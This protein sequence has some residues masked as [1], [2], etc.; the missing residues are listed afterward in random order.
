MNVVY[1]R[2][3][4]PTDV[5]SMIF[6]AGPTPRDKNVASWRGQAL[7][8]LARQGYTGTVFVPETRE[9]TFNDWGHDDVYRD[10]VEWEEAA[11]NRSDCILFWI[12]R[13]MAIMPGMTTNTEWGV[14]HDSGR[15]VL[16]TPRGAHAVKYQQYYAKKLMV[17]TAHT[18]A[19]TVAHA[20]AMVGQG[21]RRTGGECHVPLNVWRH[22]TF[23]AWLAAQRWAG[24]TLNS[25]RVLWTFRVG[26]KLDFVFCWAL[27]VNVHVQAED[28]DKT[29]EFVFGRTDMA[30]VVLWTPGP[31]G[32]FDSEARVVL[33]RE[34]R[35]PSRSADCFVRELPGGS[36]KDTEEGT[37]SVAAHEV[38]EETG[39]EIDPSRLRFI[40]TRQPVATLSAHTISLYACQLSVEEM[41]RVELDA[42][43][44]EAHGVIE[45]SERTYVEVRTLDQLLALPEV[46]W[47]TLGMITAACMGAQ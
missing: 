17:P 23:E 6:L 38:H 14:W 13:D 5:T 41:A 47:S 4:L 22:R 39:I 44:G 26:P 25:A 31:S 33:V 12:P 28:R 30:A 19:E 24:N 20:L 34:F 2:E 43:N 3:P 42:A 15:V 27:H 29:N 37:R 9:G 18:L 36:S 10:Q 16:G 8:E 45:D 35:S 46:D 11:L 32:R 40:D 7:E 21:A 1:A